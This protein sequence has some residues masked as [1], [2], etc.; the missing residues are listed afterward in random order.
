[1]V[2]QVKLG[3]VRKQSIREIWD[4]SPILAKLQSRGL[5]KGT[6]GKC[7][8]RDQCGGCRG[9]AYEETGD[10]LAEDPGCWLMK[11]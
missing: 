11:A 6:C 10:I 9:R 7:E 2:L 3:N 4:N 8:Y 1:M 5:L